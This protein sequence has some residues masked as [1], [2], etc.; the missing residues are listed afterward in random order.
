MGRRPRLRKLAIE[1]AQRFAHLADPE[2]VIA[3]GEVF[4]DGFLVSIQL[5][6]SASALRRHCGRR[7]NFVEARRSRMP[8][9]CSTSARSGPRRSG[10]RRRR[11]YPGSARRWGARVYAVD[12]GPGQLRGSLRQD[13]RL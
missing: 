1:L 8:C 10:D 4:V 13:P 12:V 7:S 5:L 9:T 3:A 2:A 6:L 11:P